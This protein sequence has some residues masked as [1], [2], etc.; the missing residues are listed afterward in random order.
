VR[1]V[2]VSDLHGFLP[3]IPRCDLLLIGGDVCPLVDHDVDF[4]ADWLS[5]TFS[6]WLEGVRAETVAG[7]AGNHDF[8]A[9]FAPDLMRGLPWRY[10]LDEQCEIG[11]L[12]IWGTPWTPRFGDW[13]FMDVEERLAERWRGV[14]AD[15]DV[16]LSHG[17]P[18][19][20]GMTVAGDDAGSPAML[21]T[22]MRVRPR[23]CLYGHIHEATGTF[24]VGPSELVNI[25]HVNE[26]YVPVHAPHSFEM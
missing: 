17:P 4:Q 3:S 6:T 26:R 23:Y 15:T 9:Q 14:A 21:D 1:V 19:G 16:L 7:I 25:S 10:L 20:Y 11:G 5:T 18:V 2:A 8:V 22:I 13:A 24:H 12:R